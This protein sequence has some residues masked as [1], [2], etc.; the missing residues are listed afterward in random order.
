M[1]ASSK[2]TD[3]VRSVRTPWEA[4]LVDA[5]RV[6]LSTAT[7]SLAMVCKQSYSELHAASYFFSCLC[8]FQM[9]TSVQ[10][11]PLTLASRSASTLWGL[12][13]VVAIPATS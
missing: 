2:Q 7:A 9:S 4:T 6:T 5:T 10:W 1:S 12:T 8:L 13:L 3:A 11:T